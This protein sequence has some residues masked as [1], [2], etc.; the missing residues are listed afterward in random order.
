M[1]EIIS[2]CFELCL[3]YSSSYSE[4]IKDKSPAST[5]PLVTD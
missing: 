2:I 4:G 5:C 1:E 3:M